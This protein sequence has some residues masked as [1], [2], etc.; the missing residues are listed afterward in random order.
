MTITPCLTAAAKNTM[1]RIAA[2][3]SMNIVTVT[4]VAVNTMIANALKN[5][6]TTVAGSMK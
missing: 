3:K 5:M 1:S 4:A 6:T 2:A